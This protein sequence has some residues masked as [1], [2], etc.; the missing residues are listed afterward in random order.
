MIAATSLAIGLPINDYRFTLVELVA[1][2]AIVITLIALA[3]PATKSARNSAENA[4]CLGNLRTLAL[5]SAIHAADHNEIL[6]LGHYN[7]SIMVTWVIKSHGPK[8]HGVLYEDVGIEP[9]F[10]PLDENLHFQAQTYNFDRN[11]LVR[12]GYDVRPFFEPGDIQWRWFSTTTDPAQLSSPPSVRDLNSG[13]TLYMDNAWRQERIRHT[14]GVN[15]VDLSGAATKYSSS[16]FHRQ[17]I[18]AIRE[19]EYQIIWDESND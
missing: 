10:C 5:N 13:S 14:S 1:V 6:P 3:L 7:H 19:T 8:L 17:N 11:F 9:Y 12:S 15:K 4:Q 18:G 2:S 16:Y